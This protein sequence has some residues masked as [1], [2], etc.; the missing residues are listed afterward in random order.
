MSS[1]ESE[2]E[3]VE[4]AGCTTKRLRCYKV[5]RLPW[6]RSKLRAIKRKLDEAHFNLVSKHGRGMMKERVAGNPSTRPVPE[7]APEWA[8]RIRQ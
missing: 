7:N 6:E 4:D 3:D 1:E 5:R 2:F 8:V